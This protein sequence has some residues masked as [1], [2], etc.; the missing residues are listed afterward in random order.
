MGDEPVFSGGGFNQ[1]EQTGAQRR[2]HRGTRLKAR[3]NGLPS[4][5]FL[6]SNVRLCRRSREGSA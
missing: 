2:Q 4:R 5:Q 6:V 1:V 3:K